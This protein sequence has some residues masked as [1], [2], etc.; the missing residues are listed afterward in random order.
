MRMHDFNEI[1]VYKPEYCFIA[2]DGVTIIP[3]QYDFARSS[4]V[5]EAIPGKAFY[6]SDE[7]NH[8]LAR[9]D[10][11]PDGTLGNLTPFVNVGEFGSA[12]DKEGNVYVA[13][14]YIYVFDKQ[15]KQTGLIRVPERPTSLVIA[16]KDG[17]TLYIAARSSLYRYIIHS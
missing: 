3:E 10:V 1:S 9:M 17:N 12:V 2:P 13:D 4:S 5:L 6:A 14:G 8:L 7:Y 15:G 11:R 16:G